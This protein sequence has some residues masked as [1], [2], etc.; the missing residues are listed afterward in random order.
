LNAP[1]SYISYFLF[2]RDINWMKIN[3]IYFDSSKTDMSHWV[4]KL[5]WYVWCR[6]RR[7]GSCVY[8]W[9]IKKEIIFNSWWRIIVLYDVDYIRPPFSYTNK[10]LFETLSRKYE[11][12]GKSLNGKVKKKQI[13]CSLLLEI[14]S[15]NW[16]FLAETN[17]QI[18]RFMTQTCQWN[19]FLNLLSHYSVR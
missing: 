15:V 19:K 6:K 10:I 16:N 5:I 18:Y 3:S 4:L 2:K 8:G 12:D 9:S 14:L 11:E 7:G 1:S 17:A 13:K